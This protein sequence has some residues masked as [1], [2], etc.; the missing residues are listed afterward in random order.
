MVK[1]EGRDDVPR[2]PREE[3]EAVINHIIVRGINQQ[4]IFRDEGD[5][6]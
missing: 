5:F 1:A 4:D 2:K 3:S 6:R